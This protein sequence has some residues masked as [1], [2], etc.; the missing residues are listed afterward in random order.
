MKHQRQIELLKQIYA[1][2]DANTTPMWHET[3]SNPAA[4]YTCPQHF[5]QELN[6]LF[7]GQMP[8]LAGFS[9]DLPAAGAWLTCDLPSAPIFLTRTTEGKVKAFLNICRHRGSRLVGFESDT[10]GHFTNHRGQ[11]Q[12]DFSCPYH[13]WTYDHSG[14]L[15]RHANDMD[16][17]VQLKTQMECGQ[18]NLVELPCLETNGMILVRPQGKEPIDAQRDTFGMHNHIGEFDFGNFYFFKEVFWKFQA[19]WKLL[20]ETFME[21]YHVATLHRNTVAPSFCCYP[22]IYECFGPNVMCM[23]PRKNIVDQRH[24]PQSEWSMTKYASTIFSVL[25]N[26][27]VN[28]PPDGHMELW[29]FQ[30][31]TVDSTRVRAR[32]YISKP[33]ANE[34]DETYWNKSWEVSKQVLSG[35]DFVQQQ[36][37]QTNLAS[38]RLPYV[39]FG[40]NEP[41]LSHFHN[42]LNKI[43]TK[44]Y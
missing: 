35:E 26:A 12:H 1:H 44:E 29:D 23:L 9:P 38:G 36:N 14:V 5:Q 18:F 3:Y 41:M 15:V 33:I 7:G 22:V 37:I 17:F 24:L 2:I 6:T 4:H 10:Q 20:L 11:S 42:A 21:G 32:F 30:P 31:L 19:N 43:I 34:A 39:N 16:G 25:P 28:I 40:Q 27:V 8:I 13:A